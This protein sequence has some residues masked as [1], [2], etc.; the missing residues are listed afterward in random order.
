MAKRPARTEKIRYDGAYVASGFPLVWFD[1][2]PLDRYPL[3]GFTLGWTSGRTGLT[4]VQILE[5]EQYRLNG[6]AIFRN[7]DVKRWR[8]ILPHE[9]LA[10]AAD[11][12]R[13]RPSVPAGLTIHSFKDA[14]LSA[15][16]AFPLVTI[17]QERIERGVCYIGKVQHASQRSVILIPISTGAEWEEPESYLLRDI[18]LIQF[19]GAYERLLD[20]L[21]DNRSRAI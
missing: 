1:R 16:K 7:S 6:Y 18:T 2:K 8:P 3:T 4:A 21:C 12:Q 17:H 14:V 10:R 5:D 15:G 19:G 20:Q 13:L 9:F 11:R